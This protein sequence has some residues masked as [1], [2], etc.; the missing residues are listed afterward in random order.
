MNASIT[1][2]SEPLVAGMTCFL[3]AFSL[4][5]TVSNDRTNH[6]APWEISAYLSR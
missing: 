5:P 3:V 2:G 4:N 6:P 1:I